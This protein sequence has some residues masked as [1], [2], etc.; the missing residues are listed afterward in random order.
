MKGV[1]LTE[2]L[3]MVE[4]KFSLAMVDHIVQASG[5]HGAYTAVG[6]YPVGEMAA[7]LG[8][9]SEATSTPPKELLGVFGRHLAGRFA[10][11]FPAFFAAS[12]SALE[13]LERVDDYIHVEVR[14]LYPD[15]ELPTFECHRPG[16]GALVMTY[17]S[18][19][20]LADFAE[21]LMHGVAEHYG[22]LLTIERDDLS[23]GR[24]ERVR[25]TLRRVGP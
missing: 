17:S 13:F 7:L 22:E 15:A 6:T 11:G 9:L 19:R 14:K 8:A 4:E 20:R 10:R 1:V 25:F 18:P 3:E 5:V 16:P 24:G 23:E 2:L 21:G 12:Q